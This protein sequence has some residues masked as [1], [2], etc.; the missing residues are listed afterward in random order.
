[1]SAA[2]RKPTPRLR[3]AWRF[4]YC[5]ATGGWRHPYRG[6]PDVSRAALRAYGSRASGGVRKSSTGTSGG[7]RGIGYW[8][9]RRIRSRR[10][11][12]IASAS[13]I[14]GSMISV[15]SGLTIFS[16]QIALW[17]AEDGISDGGNRFSLGKHVICPTAACQREFARSLDH[18]LLD[19][20]ISI[21]HIDKQ[22]GVRIHQLKPDD[23]AYER[24]GRAEIVGDPIGVMRL[25][26]KRRH[27][28][29]R[30]GERG[31]LHAGQSS[32]HHA[33]GITQDS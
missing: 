31:G 24:F 16:I 3:R 23:F 26:K 6:T 8:F 21:C 10:S 19:V 14:N 4:S 13:A 33:S 29:Q 9:A 17:P 12:S 5:R 32:G 20:A 18:P 15:P 27:R 1:M 28:H 22:S 25:R 30:D 2:L 7:V 11:S